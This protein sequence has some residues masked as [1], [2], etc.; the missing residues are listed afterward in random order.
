MTAL[1]LGSAAILWFGFN[2]RSVL[3][4]PDA[5]HYT[6][7]DFDIK[8]AQIVTVEPEPGVTLTGWYWPPTSPDMKTVIYFHGNGDGIANALKTRV[9]EPFLGAGHGFLFTTY[10][11]FNGN[12]GTMGE[13][14]LYNDARAWMKSV[15]APTDQIVL[16]GMSLGTGIAVTMATEYPD[17]AGVILE[18]PYTS[19]AALI[20]HKYPL[21]PFSW[22]LRHRFDS[23]SRIGA[24]TKPV[25]VM[26]GGR[27]TLVPV[28][29]GRELCTAAP[30]CTLKIYDG[31][32]HLD[33][34]RHGAYGEALR[35]LRRAVGRSPA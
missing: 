22:A 31:A 16:Y 25:L 20:R 7:A 26:H 34:N 4:L 33:L 35:F 12:P 5:A 15:E 11:G 28:A 13:D 30:D 10:R 6:P 21:V 18:A 29:Q 9:M 27:D 1:L 24:V 3:F 14:A 23:L 8:G 32:G 2:Q 19:F 17:V